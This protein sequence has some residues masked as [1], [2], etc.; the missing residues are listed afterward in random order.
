MEALKIVKPIDA[1]SKHVH[2]RADRV[3]IR[4][5]KN[6]EGEKIHDLVN[7]NGFK[8]NDLDWSDIH[9]FW[10]AAVDEEDSIL[11][12]L[13]VCV[14]RP[15]GRIEMLSVKPDVTPI[16]RAIIVKSL[17]I[18]ATITLKKGRAQL[19]S[20]L[21]PFDMKSYKKILKKRGCVVIASGNLMAKKL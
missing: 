21:I 4:L 16:E 15:I 8:I 18:A 11:G 5:A 19:A 1:E 9:P 6:E 10:L 3:S 14:S 20:G 12:C 17:I 7:K 2:S 13:Q